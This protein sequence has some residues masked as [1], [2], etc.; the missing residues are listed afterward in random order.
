MRIHKAT[1]KYERWLARHCDVVQADLDRKHALMR[2]SA[3]CFLRGTFYRWAQLWP[4]VCPKLARAPEV[5]AVGDLHVE[6]FG[7]WRDA[8]GRLVWG[9]NDFDE[10]APLSYAN[11]LVRLATSAV[12]AS[13]ESRLNL[14]PEVICRLIF[15]GYRDTLRAGGWPFILDGQHH[16]L[17]HAATASRRGPAEFWAALRKLPPAG[18]RLSEGARKTLL[19]VTPASGAKLVFKRRVAG[20]GSLG[21]E[22]FVALAEW[23]GGLVAREAKSWVPSAVLWAAGKKARSN[24]SEPITRKAVRSPDPTLRFG[25]SWITR[26]LAPD[27]IRIDLADLARDRDEHRLLF[28]MGAET[29]NIH[30]GDRKAAARVLQHVGRTRDA[31]L[32]KAAVL[33]A[34]AVMD[35]WRDFRRA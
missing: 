14:S 30:A 7:T 27:C 20:V 25:R 12:L 34:A 28:A 26:R 29:A 33:M 4:A 17:R 22:R 31:W 11:D 35:D 10:A 18:S 3:F 32:S 19:A 5:V 2:E 9:I 13:G 23:H 24:Y 15:R 8:E 21:R 1:R 6:N 16:W